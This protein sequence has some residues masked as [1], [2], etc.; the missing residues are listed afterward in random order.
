MLFIICGCI[1]FIFL[2]E[3]ISKTVVFIT[4]FLI[5][6]ALYGWEFEIAEFLGSEEQARYHISYNQGQDDL[7]IILSN[8][9]SEPDVSG[10]LCTVVS[11]AIGWLSNA[12]GLP[13]GSEVELIPSEI[14]SAY[15][16]FQGRYVWAIFSNYALYKRYK[17]SFH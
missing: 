8:L 4:F 5:S 15:L 14:G 9:F 3:M 17:V 1:I 11:R 16:F 7:L 6:Q 10:Y 2:D 13:L 12:R